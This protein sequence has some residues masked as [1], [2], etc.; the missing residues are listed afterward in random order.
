MSRNAGWF[1]HDE[2][3][4][5]D[6]KCT[7]LI[8]LHG[9]AAYGAWWAVCE[10]L[11]EAEDHRMTLDDRTISTLAFLLKLQDDDLRAMIET[12]ASDD[13]G[14]LQTDGTYYWSESMLRRQQRRDEIR[15]Q[16]AEIG[17]L[18]G[19]ANAK[20]TLSNCLA[21]AK[22]TL[23]KPEAN[24]KQNQA[25]KSKSKRE[26]KSEDKTVSTLV[27][28]KPP[29]TAESSLYTSIKDAFESQYGE[30]DPG[31]YGKE[32]QAIKG[33]IAKAETRAGP[34]LAADF[35]KTAIA[36]FWQLK[37]EGQKLFADQ[38]FLP[39]TLNSAGIW[40]RVIE[41]MR[42]AKEPYLGRVEEDI[43]F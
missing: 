41:T 36:R 39:S 21:N 1:Q 27:S 26:S 43:P 16:R 25:S 31:S 10:L 30:F 24:P 14:L 12:M 34:D 4:L 23:S 19:E 9:A 17:K 20:Q 15:Q 35:L 29:K 28:Q 32:G 37:Q 6:R 7:R 3:A 42:K 33:L 11:C 38:P 5:H 13:V 22:Q 2:N 40:S 18:G 8:I